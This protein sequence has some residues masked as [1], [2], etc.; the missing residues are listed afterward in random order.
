MLR[1]GMTLIPQDPVLLEISV[2]ANLDIEGIHSDDEIWRALG[3]S[4]VRV[5]RSISRLVVQ[6]LFG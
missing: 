6:L 2:R 5:L 3:L 4:S 1:S